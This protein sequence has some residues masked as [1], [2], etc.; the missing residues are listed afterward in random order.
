MAL[1]IDIIGAELT[2]NIDIVAQSVGNI[3]VDIAAQAIGN[4]T[5]DIAA[6]SVGNLS[7]NLAASAITLDINIAT[8]AVTLDMNIATCAATL[9]ISVTAQEI[10]LD[11]NIMGPIGEYQAE[12]TADFSLYGQA[13]SRRAEISG[14]VETVKGAGERYT[15]TNSTHFYGPLLTIYTSAATKLTV[16]CLRGA[17]YYDFADIHMA[18]GERSMHHIRD[19]DGDMLRAWIWG[20]V[21]LVTESAATIWAEISHCP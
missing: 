12:V 14:G 10:D 5:I 3:S 6:Q 20:D 13:Y 19:K 15:L 11:I 16:Q 2:L 7:I 21:H 18:A 8:S 1:D 9:D 4:L 17:N